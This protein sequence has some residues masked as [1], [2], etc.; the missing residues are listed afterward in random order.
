LNAF[1]KGPQRNLSLRE[2]EI[3]PCVLHPTNA[4]AND[5]GETWNG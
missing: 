4:P 5:P 1:A 2:K 3:F